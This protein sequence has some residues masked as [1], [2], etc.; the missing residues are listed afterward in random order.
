MQMFVC[1]CVCFVVGLGIRTSLV[2]PMGRCTHGT[3]PLC[4]RFM[5]ALAYSAPTGVGFFSG[6]CGSGTALPQAISTIFPQQSTPTDMGYCG[7]RCGSGRLRHKLLQPLAYSAPTEVGTRS[8][9]CRSAL[10][11]QAGLWGQKGQHEKRLPGRARSALSKS[12]R[13]KA[14]GTV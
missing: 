6:L 12:G 8:G 14:V 13:P 5:Q 4:H 9:L 10:S 1:A 2:T 7:G 3:G 11:S